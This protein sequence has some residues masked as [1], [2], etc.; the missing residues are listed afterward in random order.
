MTQG[1]C[2]EPIS[3]SFEPHRDG[4]KL[5]KAQEVGRVILPAD[6]HAP[7]PLQPGKEALH[8]P[9]TLIAAERA[10]VLGLEF[11]GGP[12][13]R[14]HIHAVVVEVVIQPITVIRAITDEVLRFGLPHVEVKTE[15]HQ[16]DLMMIGRV[17]ESG[18]P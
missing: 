8:E 3:K 17:R 7:L 1:C 14:N 12:M 4:G 16:R 13:W 2:L 11:P 5:D 10:A 9:A 15:L 18:S 6:E